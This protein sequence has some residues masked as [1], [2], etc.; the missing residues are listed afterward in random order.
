MKRP[1]LQP[2]ITRVPQIAH[3]IKKQTHTIIA[4][5]DDLIWIL[6]CIDTVVFADLLHF[7]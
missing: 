3:H 2:R 5:K 6:K 7:Y 1:V 4:S